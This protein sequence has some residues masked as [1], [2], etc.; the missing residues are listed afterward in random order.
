MFIKRIRIEGF[1]SLRSI[2]L[3]DLAPSL[4]A[5]IGHNGSGKS[6]IYEALL[7]ALN[8]PSLP[9]SEEARRDLL[10]TSPDTLSATVSV[11]FANDQ[12]LIP[13]FDT[14]EVEVSRL[15]SLKR[16]SFM[17]NGKTLGTQEFADFLET[18]GISR[19]N[20]SSSAED[21]ART[22][23]PGYNFVFRQGDVTR[24][25]HITPQELLATIRG[26]VGSTDYSVRRAAAVAKLE[27]ARKKRLMAQDMIASIASKLS[28]LEAQKKDLEAYAEEVA[29]QKCAEH[30]LLTMDIR[31]CTADI[32]E[33]G[34]AVAQTE[35]RLTAARG[36]L[37]G[38][39]E[40]ASA[41]AA[42]SRALH[43]L[44]AG[45]HGTITAANTALATVT[46]H[47]SEILCATEAFEG[48]TLGRSQNGPGSQ[49]AMFT[50]ASGG[51]HAA[52]QEGLLR[53]RE[54]YNGNLQALLDKEAVLSNDMFELESRKAEV[55]Q[56]IDSL[57]L[58]TSLLSAADRLRSLKAM[59]GTHE[60][61]VARARQLKAEADACLADRTAEHRA[62]E[63]RLS[64]HRRVLTALQH[65]EAYLEVLGQKELAA[66]TQEKMT[67][68]NRDVLRLDRQ[69]G[70]AEYRVSTVEA[71]L[72]NSAPGLVGGTLRVCQNIVA[73]SKVIGVHG[74]LFSILSCKQ[75][76]SYAVETAAGPT[77]LFSLVVDKTDTAIRLIGLM[78][79]EQAHSRARLGKINFLPL[80]AVGGAQSTGVEEGLAGES[81]IVPFTELLQY[82]AS[83]FSNVV[84]YVFGRAYLAKDLD[85][86]RRVSSA[87]GVDCY[88]IEGDCVQGSGIVTG[89]FKRT[90]RMRVAQELRTAR[91]EVAALRER[92]AAATQQLDACRSTLLRAQQL[93]E[94][95]KASFAATEASL[96]ELK[97]K[98][99]TE[100]ALGRDLQDGLHG[101]ASISRERGRSLELAEKALDKLRAQHR[102]QGS[103]ADAESVHTGAVPADPA[104]LAE[105]D[106]Q[107]REEISALRATDLRELESA[108]AACSRDLLLVKSDIAVLQAH[109]K[110]M[111]QD[112]KAADARASDAPEKALGALGALS[113]ANPANSLSSLGSLDVDNAQLARSLSVVTTTLESFCELCREPVSAL[114]GADGAD[115]VGAAAQLSEA[116]RRLRDA[117]ALREAQS[118][119]ASTAA[120]WQAV[121]GD[122]ASVTALLRAV[123]AALSAAL[124][125]AQ[126]DE[127]TRASAALSLAAE[128]RA[129][130]DA[131][132]AL[133]AEMG[134]MTRRRHAIQERLAT[135]EGARAALG[136]ALG[137]AESSAL[138]AQ[139]RDRH[140]TRLELA[141][142]LARRR[143]RMNQF[144]GLNRK[145]ADQYVAL[146]SEEA[147]LSRQLEDVVNSELAIKQL[148]A[149][150]DARQARSLA[151]TFRHVG[152]QFA[153][154]FAEL[155][156]GREGALTVELP[157]G[158]VV[159]AHDITSATPLDDAVAVN[160]RVDLAGAGP[161]RAL[162]LRDLS[163][164]QQTVVSLCLMLA[165]Q[166]VDA[167]P[168]LVLDEVDAMLDTEYRVALAA[169]LAARARAGQQV[170][171]TSFRPEVLR[172]ADK[173]FGVRIADGGSV[174]GEATLADALTIVAEEGR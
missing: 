47:Y 168:L 124:A 101:A 16:D 69:L 173:I 164:G 167:C 122:V 113:V 111:G 37:T 104:G 139:T 87:W 21:A 26:S 14:P 119:E 27:G 109:L 149:D 78:R 49:D 114:R 172:A 65:D 129:A 70:D 95:Q 154:V 32:E 140:P 85:V 11:V 62:S 52:G 23:R 153:E 1:R 123:R 60:H 73:R 53:R 81:G 156:S 72:Y 44:R 144:A 45:L 102:E 36:N 9:T 67:A 138:Y 68:L 7:Y 91:S 77:N 146:R 130:Q 82:D 117:S 157:G 126:E 54:R 174:V 2:L 83:L 163:G 152:A 93:I 97:G 128:T 131:C 145:A 84:S 3:T 106:E 116:A 170:L 41:S 29:G 171:V 137:A 38:L 75:E 155:T 160:V 58:Q 39:E 162:S 100:S 51:A 28:G 127:E 25:S 20:T 50:D 42:A 103:P 57:V 151:E 147:A 35:G 132:T 169:L 134:D 96:A 86:A 161:G 112:G 121:L 80:D 150:I 79:A 89:G 148:M 40:Q 158:V 107:L 33:I 59:I 10:H 31:Q 24:L 18:I 74:T 17:I 76:F 120:F 90:T 108:A 8:D 12:R 13:G 22:L 71:E 94:G 34:A 125:R 46:E 159:G 141:A 136:T 99:R 30:L 55:R 88:T 48:A 105:R 66:A 135:L 110:N 142:E 56:R 92:R 19:S 5:I 165:M 63:E 61:D 64:E 98:I 43:D 166:A 143:Q 133:E 118:R 115:A 6:N 15:I 4:N